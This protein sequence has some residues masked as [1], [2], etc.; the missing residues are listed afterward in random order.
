M[1]CKQLETVIAKAPKLFQ[2]TPL[3]LDISK[4]QEQPV[5]LLML[6]YTLQDFGIKLVGLQGANASTEKEAEALG[7]VILHA[8]PNQD[9]VLPLA[10]TEEGSDRFFP[11]GTKLYTSQIRSGQQVVCK[12]GDLIITASVSHGAEL[13]ADGNIHVYGTLR[14]RALAGISGDTNARIFCQALEAELVSIAGFYKLSEAISLP[15]GPCQIYL[16]EEHIQIEP[17]C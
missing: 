17:V 10:Q 11:G 12:G 13:L 3:V 4:V 16:K 5:D 6:R 15:K 2:N 1:L 7:F 14:G 8:S 9:K